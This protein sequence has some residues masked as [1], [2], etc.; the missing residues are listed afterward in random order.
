M[1]AP[2]P[3]P[4]WQ[5]RG[6]LQYG[7]ENTAPDD[8]RFSLGGRSTVRRI[9]E[10]AAADHRGYAVSL[11]YVHTAS[12][13]V[14]FVMFVDHGRV[15]PATGSAPTTASFTSMDLGVDWRPFPTTLASLVVGAPVGQ[16]ED[17]L[18]EPVHAQVQLSF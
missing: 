5:V 11:E 13:R 3:V 12:D 16:V 1:W 14:E 15:W 7:F 6:A 10:G 4:R 18:R 9:Q 17:S 8:E 2:T